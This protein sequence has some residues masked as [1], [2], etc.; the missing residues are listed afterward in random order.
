[1]IQAW[2]MQHWHVFVFTLKRLISTPVTS[3]LSV[4]VIGIA[5]S[6]PAGIYIL[7]DNLRS[8]SGQAAGSPQMSLYFKTD[9]SKSDI[10]KIRQRLEENAQIVHLQFISKKTALQQL[11][12]SSGVVDITSGL[13]RN[14]LPDAFVV[15]T[16]DSTAEA[17][18]QLQTTM[19]AWPKIEHVQFDA[20]WAKRL[21]TMIEFGRTV[22]LMLSVLLS[23]AIIAVMFNTIRLQILTKREEI[24]VSKL[25]GATN[26]FI[27]RPFLYFGAIQGL[28]GGITALCIIALAIQ[29]LNEELT[30]IAQLYTLNL[31][32]QHL[33]TGD[34]I[35][36][37]LFSTWLGWLG[38]RISVATHLWQ[39]EPK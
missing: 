37:L 36:L 10:E 6:L 21:N 19:Q 1:M 22:V 14:P 13:A 5:F 25:I 23:I 4:I 29:T 20:A 30:E 24:E 33:S 31:H 12:Q 7:M 26:S 34:N 38:A 3:L 35:S 15:N 32:L 18:K 2:L 8:I 39:I 16:L 17:L 27:Q 11:Q 9:A 28:L